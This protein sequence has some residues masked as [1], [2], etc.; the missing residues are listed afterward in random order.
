M[1]EINKKS[2]A[3]LL[4][5]MTDKQTELKNFRFGLAGSKTKNLREGRNLRREI[6]TIKTQLPFAENK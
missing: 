2:K 6:A 4:K 1:T 3:E 5:M